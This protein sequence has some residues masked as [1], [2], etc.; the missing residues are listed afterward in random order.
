MPV[1]PDSYYNSFDATKNHE[2][3]L[4][5]DGFTLQGA[6]LNAMQSM[7]QKRLKNVADALFKDGD[8]IRDAQIVIDKTSGAVQASSGAIYLNGAVRGIPAAEFQIPVSGT[9]AIG[10]R[11]AERVISELDDPSL[12]NPAIGSRGEGEPGAWRLRTD[13]AWA[14]DGDNGNGEFYPV[15]TVDDGIIRAKEAPPTMDT[16]TQGIAKY[17]R[18]STAGGSYVVNGLTVLQ[19]ENDNNGNQVYTLSEGRARVNGY[20]VDIPTSRRLTYAAKP[21]LRQIDTEVHSAD[22]SSMQ[23]GGQRINIAHPPLHQIDVVRIT[24]RKTVS[25]THGAYSGAQDALPDTAVVNIVECRQGDTVYSAGLDFRKTGD[26]VDWSPAGAEPATGSTYLC[27]YDSIAVTSPLKI[28]Y[29]GFSVEGAVPGSSILISYKQALPRIDRLALTQEGQALWF[30]GVAAEMYARA[31]VIPAHLL[32]LATVNQTW[33]DIRSVVSDAVRVVPFDEIESI[34]QRID[35]ALAEIARQRLEADVSTRESG[36]RVGIFVDPLLDDSMRDQGLEQSAAI[37]NGSL[38]LPIQAAV[39]NLSGIKTVSLAE[40][41][42]EVVLAQLYRTSGM[43]VNPYMVFDVLPA[44]VSLNPAI[45]QWTDIESSWTSA[46]TKR[47]D[48]GHYQATNSILSNQ[49]VSIATETVATS[50]RNLEYLRQIA[51]A[52]QLEGFG[53]GE[54]L[55]SVIFDGIAA[56]FNA[57]AADAAGVL[58]GSFII[59]AKVPAGA[60]TVVFRGNPNGGSW[61]SAV[62][63]GQ[64]R[65]TVQTMRQV[66]TVVNYWVENVDPLAQTFTLDETAQ[67][68]GVDLWFTAKEGEVRVQIREVQ[69]GVPARIILAEAILQAKQ[70]TTENTPT[71][72]LFDIPVQLLAGA[73]YALVILCNDATTA[74][75]IAEMGKFDSSLQRWVTSQPYTVGVLLSSSNASTWTAHQ[76]KD[77]AFRLLKASFTDNSNHIELGTV[78]VENLTDLLLLAVDEQP[79]ADSRVE[80][81]IALPDGKALRMAQGQ[82]ARLPDPVSGQVSVSANLLGSAKSAPLLWPGA[83]LLSGT[84]AESADYYSRSIPA[85]GAS[86]AVLIYDAEIPSGASV[87]PRIRKDSGAWTELSASANT[88]Q[89]D[90]QAEYRFET[91]LSNVNE[92]KLQ[93]SLTGTSSARPVVRNI[94]LMAVI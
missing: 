6:E 8:I 2:S 21:N 38:Q 27:T 87:T 49:S 42:P 7:Q 66:H 91:P 58:T 94:R 79:S 14:Y 16:F 63:V 52:F 15:Y 17:D 50:T 76:D 29:D 92:I 90:G 93:L 60:K 70:I 37:L 61:G 57:T 5:R 74:V 77:L 44:R 82:A 36:A 55:D 62:F 67:I 22:P 83:Q 89:G 56:T 33:R 11:I 64:G 13:I 88:P 43:K 59:P 75:A 39:Q 86:K 46:I 25:L 47:F 71:R 1:M 78:T 84:I 32:P 31:P 80:Y 18:D 69:N 45:D 3:I 12:Y 35:F 4:F 30:Q 73:E 68:C 20:G 19:A 34:N 41:T 51:V 48:T 24:T 23:A 54:V 10:V 26:K 81:E 85:V 65:L 53:A 9:V 28:D 40:F 72:A